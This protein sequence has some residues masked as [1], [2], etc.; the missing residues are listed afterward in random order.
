MIIGEQVWQTSA[1]VVRDGARGAG[2]RDTQTAFLVAVISLAAKVSKAHGHVSGG[3]DPHLR[4]FLRDHLRMSPEDC[5]MAAASST[6][7]ATAPSRPATSP[8]RCAATWTV[9]ERLRLIVT[10]LLQIKPTPTA[11]CTRPRTR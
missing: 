2:V 4:R 3:G 9:P 10:L 8:A 7:P 11:V 5:R 1:Q 6:S